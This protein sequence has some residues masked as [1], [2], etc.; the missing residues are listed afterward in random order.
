MSYDLYSGV[1]IKAAFSIPS[2]VVGNAKPIG[3]NGC[4]TSAFIPHKV[5]AIF[6]VI[7]F[8]PTSK[9]NRRKKFNETC[10][11]DTC[12]GTGGTGTCLAAGSTS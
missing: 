8:W 9:T 3:N 10:S 1:G 7:W 2:H 5:T 11:T 6:C 12:T 4:N